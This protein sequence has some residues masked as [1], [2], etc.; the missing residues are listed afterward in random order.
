V[1]DLLLLG[2]PAG[3]QGDAFD[4]T[5]TRIRSIAAV[6]RLLADSRGGNVQAAAILDAV[7]SI[8]PARVSVEADPVPSRRRLRRPR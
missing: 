4:E 6:H 8:A 3:T 7:A 2:R 1:A 5:A